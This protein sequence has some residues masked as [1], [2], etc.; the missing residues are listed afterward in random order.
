[1]N[2]SHLNIK[3][4]EVE[5]TMGLKPFEA[6]GVSEEKYLK[7]KDG[8]KYTRLCEVLRCYKMQNQ[9]PSKGL[10]YYVDRFRRF[11]KI[12]SDEEREF[13]L[14]LIDDVVSKDDEKVILKLQIQAKE[15]E[16]SELKSK[17]KHL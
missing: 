3:I 10:K 16:L 17:Y 6:I 9:T 4:R 12:S 14:S 7:W 11:L 2:N 8:T 13:L 15:R 5:E 1:M